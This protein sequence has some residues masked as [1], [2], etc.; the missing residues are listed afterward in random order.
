MRNMGSDNVYI[1]MDIEIIFKIAAVGLT[2][3]I[4]NTLLSKAGRDEYVMLTTLSGIIIV[5][6][7]LIDD[8]SNLFNTLRNLFDV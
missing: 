7:F 3:S 2:V 6:L 8:I 4:V 1:I 5:V